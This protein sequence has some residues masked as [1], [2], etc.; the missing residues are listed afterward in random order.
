VYRAEWDRRL[1]LLPGTVN[2]EDFL[3]IARELKLETA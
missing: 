2:D 3:V 1:A